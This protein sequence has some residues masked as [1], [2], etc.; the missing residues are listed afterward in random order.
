MTD[1]A[2]EFAEVR[3]AYGPV[4]ALCGIS[5]TVPQ[6]IAF[7]LVGANGAGK[8]TLIK[9]M[10]DFVHLDGGTIRLLGVAHRSVTARRLLAYLPENFLPP[11]YLTGRE[12]LHYLQSLRGKPYREE[13]VLALCEALD[14]EPAALDRLARTY[15]KGM[16]RKLGLAACLASQAR[17]FVLDEPM[18][19]LDPKARALLKCQLTTLTA[20]GRTVFMSTHSLADVEELCAGMA[21]LHEGRLCF[22]G[23]P[24]ACRA[25][26]ASGTLEEAY[27][28]AIA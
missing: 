12:F 16:T 28:A 6:G 25:Q 10:L 27:L 3:K 13:E 23:T 8:T 9:C 17:L 1:A 7:G 18:S 2:I 15:S 26:Y 22:A 14:L 20:A 4:A 19:G 5:F 21:I 24:A 11:H